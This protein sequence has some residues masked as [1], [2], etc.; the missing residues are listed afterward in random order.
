MPVPAFDPCVGPIALLCDL[1][2][3]AVGSAQAAAS[4]YVFGGLAH[5]LVRPPTPH[6][7]AR[8]RGGR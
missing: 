6:R 1:T 7:T 3:N 4:D 5:A 2:S 8:S